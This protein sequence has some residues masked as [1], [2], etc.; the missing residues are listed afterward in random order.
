MLGGSE[1]RLRQG[2]VPMAQSTWTAQKRR[3]A[4]RGPG[5]QKKLLILLFVQFKDSHEGLGGELNGT[6]T[7]HLLFAL[8][9]FL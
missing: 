3:P 7:P 8:F 4:L 1:S 6:Q 9:L 5:G 2:F